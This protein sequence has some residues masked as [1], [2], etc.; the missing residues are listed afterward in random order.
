MPQ[1]CARAR[2]AGAA[3]LHTAPHAFCSCPTLTS[4]LA[5]HRPFSGYF[6]SETGYKKSKWYV[7]NGA[8]FCIAWLLVRILYAMPMGGFLVYRHFEQL[9]Q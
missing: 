9:S 6:L 4:S 1:H 2:H 5:P 8:V 3:C 7:L